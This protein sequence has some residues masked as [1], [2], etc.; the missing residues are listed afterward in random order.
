MSARSGLLC[1]VRLRHAEDV[2]H[3]RHHRLEVQLRRL[4]Q[5]SGVAE[6]VELEESGAALHLRLHHGGRSHLREAN[7]I[8]QT[9]F[10]HRH[11]LQL[12]AH[13]EVATIEVV[14]AE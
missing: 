6:V 7:V 5:V 11:R 2:S 8:D 12:K 4:R 9:E 1:S 14:G 3:R 13:L 10:L